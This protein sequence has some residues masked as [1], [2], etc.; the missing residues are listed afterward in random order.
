MSDC[1]TT[2]EDRAM[3]VSGTAELRHGPG[4]AYSQKA[5]LSTGD[6]VK[7]KAEAGEW[8]LVETSGGGTGFVQKSALKVAAIVTEPKCVFGPEIFSRSEINPWYQKGQ[9]RSVYEVDKEIFKSG[10]RYNDCWQEVANKP[11]CYMFQGVRFTARIDS[12][13]YPNAAD[14]T[15]PSISWSGKCVNGV[16]QGK[17][18]MA[19]KVPG[20]QIWTEKNMVFVDGKRHER[21]S[22]TH[23]EGEWVKG[24]KQGKWITNHPNGNRDIYNYLDGV[25]HGLRY[26]YDDNR[27]FYVKYQHGRLPFSEA[28]RT[29]SSNCK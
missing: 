22:N 9:G 17:G 24:L 1:L 10:V 8:T 18:D 5:N 19:Y 25:P 27:C 7:V 20:W 13:A 3:E 11:G 21:V 29:S 4:D 12:G 26:I 2:V 6:K 28:R 16:V 15:R 23:Y 14:V